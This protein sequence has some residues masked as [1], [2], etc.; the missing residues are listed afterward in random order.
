MELLLKGYETWS[1]NPAVT[2]IVTWLS[3]KRYRK[4]KIF[5]WNRNQNLIPL[6]VP[7]WIKV[8]KELFCGFEFIIGQSSKPVDILQLLILSQTLMNMILLVS[9]LSLFAIGNSI[10]G[11]NKTGKR[12]IR[13]K[14]NCLMIIVILIIEHY[15]IIKYYM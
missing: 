13:N 9:F 7:N 11:S 4:K 6:W 14:W 15:H 3:S 2:F 12:W 8:I 5:T 10:P 1:K